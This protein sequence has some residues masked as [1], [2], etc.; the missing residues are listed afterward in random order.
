MNTL[1]LTSATML[2]LILTGCAIDQ[3]D[4]RQVVTS[5]VKQSGQ[6]S[7]STAKSAGETMKSFCA[8]RHIDYQTGKAP[9]GA[10]TPEQKAADDRLCDALGRQG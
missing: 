4:G 5:S 2:A 1:K 6:S 7:A 8:Q 9:G 10:K 3:Q